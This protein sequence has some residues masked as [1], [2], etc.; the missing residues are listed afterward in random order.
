MPK[1]P[2]QS[3]IK[4]KFGG[5]TR[6]STSLFSDLES[7]NLRLRPPRIQCLSP[8][9]AP[10]IRLPAGNQQEMGALVEQ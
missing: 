9:V 5:S 6:T 2:K 3:Y 8:R 4:L 10:V 7:E 1:H